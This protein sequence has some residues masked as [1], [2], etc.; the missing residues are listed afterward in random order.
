MNREI[1]T[2]EDWLEAATQKLAPQELPRLQEEIR[3]HYRDA[4][5]KYQADGVV[6]LEAQKLALADLGDVKRANYSYCLHY[7]TQGDM[8]NLKAS[9]PTSVMSVVWGVLGIIAVALI[10]RFLGIGFDLAYQWG[11]IL[12][13]FVASSVVQ[14]YLINKVSIELSYRVAILLSMGQSMIIMASIMGR[15]IAH[16]E[17]GVLLVF[18]P[19]FGVI[20][21]R[22]L[23]LYVKLLR[24]AHA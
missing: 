8:K 23:P 16:I 20:L 6:Y 14:L 21:W 3:Q 24:R 11:A 22:N 15:N 12:G 7:L 18:L 9:M 13:T 2:V 17:M 1:V 19:T 10:V 5:Q 4:L